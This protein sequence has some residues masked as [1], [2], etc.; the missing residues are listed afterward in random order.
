[1]GTLA[2]DGAGRPGRKKQSTRIDHSTGGDRRLQHHEG[3]E[4]IIQVSEVWRR[5]GLGARFL[6]PTSEELGLGMTVL[7]LSSR[8]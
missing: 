5:R 1:M 3:A 7:T 6:L 8:A 4:S 2:D